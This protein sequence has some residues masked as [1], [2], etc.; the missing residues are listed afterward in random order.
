MKFKSYHPILL[1]LLLLFGGNLLL[2]GQPI[3]SIQEAYNSGNYNKVI[4]SYN[5]I[6]E[7][8]QLP[9][10][11]IYQVGKS[12]QKQYDWKR[13]LLLFYQAYHK[14]TSFYSAQ[15]AI[16]ATHAQLGDWH[17]AQKVY[18]H[19]LKIEP[20]NT[21]ILLAL[22]EIQIH[23]RTW[24]KALKTFNAINLD[25]PS[26]VLQYKKG[27]CYFKIDSLKKARQYFE[28][29]FYLNPKNSKVAVYLYQLYTKENA[30][31]K[32]VNTLLKALQFHPKNGQLWQYLG[33]T[34]YQRDSFQLAINDYLN[35]RK[36]GITTTTL[37]R[38]IGICY[39]KIKDFDKAIR[40][41]KEAHLADGKDPMIC[42]Y[43]A[44][45]YIQTDSLNKAQTFLQLAKKLN[46]NTLAVN[47]QTRIAEVYRKKGKL[48]KEMNAYKEALAL[49]P[50][51]NAIYFRL[52]IA[53]DKYYKDKRIALRY[54]Q[55]YLIESD[56]TDKAA[57]IYV[58]ARIK[59][60]QEWIKK[61]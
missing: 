40:I 16:A 17:N 28:Q 18:Q 61:K 9:A 57:I 29:S 26:S 27:Y 20:K 41:L 35:S 58:K 42:Y 48:T 38:K 52:G 1:S 45:G 22:G 32:S 34:N 25:K 39:I 33:N 15:F 51:L 4:Q 30:L 59:V 56:S 37:L 55:K 7:K 21:S 10:K 54:Y 2:F 47:I 19:L 6:Q 5:Q 11:T 53:A 60:L 43:L 14:D 44:V 31:D 8:S 24:K 36:H 50:S 13:A 12:Y 23:L 46:T 49:D 3:S